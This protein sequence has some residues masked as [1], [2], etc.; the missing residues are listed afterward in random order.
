MTNIAVESAR[1][2]EAG[3]TVI[4]LERDY[5]STQFLKLVRLE[6]QLHSALDASPRALLLDLSDTAFIGAA[7]LSVLI[8][9]CTRS[10]ILSCRFALCGIQN[11]PADVVSITHLSTTLADVYLAT[12]CR[13]S[14]DLAFGEPTI[15]GAAAE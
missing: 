9:C 4:R 7:F 11:F 3:V 6:T 12:D 14:P 1:D 2:L 13:R 8:R 10:T 15:D 5:G